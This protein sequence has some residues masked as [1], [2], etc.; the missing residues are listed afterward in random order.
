MIGS[1][2]SLQ[3][4]CR[5]VYYFLKSQSLFNNSSVLVVKS[6]IESPFHAPTAAEIKFGTWSE[7]HDCQIARSQS[8]FVDL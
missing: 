6:A 3:L 7:L 5:I 2:F 8:V 1:E 4:R